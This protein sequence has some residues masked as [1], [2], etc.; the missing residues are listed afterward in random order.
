[1]VSYVDV[2]LNIKFCNMFLIAVNATSVQIFGRDIRSFWMFRSVGGSWWRF[3]T[4]WP[5][6]QG[7]NRLLERSQ[8][9]ELLFYSLTGLN[10]GDYYFDPSFTTRYTTCRLKST[11]LFMEFAFW[12]SA[13]NLF[14]TAWTIKYPFR[15]FFNCVVC[16]VTIRGFWFFQWRDTFIGW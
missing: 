6:M 16:F 11:F 14:G 1:M 7:S 12:I 15:V 9:C 5:H 2:K 3:G 13:V 8:A 10:Y 4:C